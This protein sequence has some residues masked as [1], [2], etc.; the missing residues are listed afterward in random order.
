MNG[1]LD[2]ETGDLGSVPGIAT[3]LIWDLRQVTSLFCASVPIMGIIYPCCKALCI[4]VATFICRFQ[5]IIIYHIYIS[6]RE[7]NETCCLN[8]KF[9][10]I[11]AG[12]ECKSS[13]C[14]VLSVVSTLFLHLMYTVAELEWR[15]NIAAKGNSEKGGESQTYRCGT[16]NGTFP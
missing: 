7:Q 8:H 16:W 13:H 12:L 14:T 1:E 3:D 11:F 6:S 10:L 4:P 5:G 9:E 15:T 2:W